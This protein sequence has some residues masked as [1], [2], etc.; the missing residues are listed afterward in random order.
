MSFHRLL[1]TGKVCHQ[2][3][4][5][6]EHACVDGLLKMVWQHKLHSDCHKLLNDNGEYTASNAIL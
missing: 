6:M 2:V 3:I 5:A 4:V 1:G